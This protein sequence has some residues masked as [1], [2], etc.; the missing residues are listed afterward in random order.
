MKLF[1]SSVFLQHFAYGLIIPTLLLWQNQ[2]GLSFAEIG[3]I[4]T[5][6]VVTILLSEVPSSYMADKVGKKFTICLAFILSIVSFGVLY[7]ADSFWLFAISQFLFNLGLAFFSGTQESF[8]HDLVGEE[9]NMTK[10]LGRLSIVDESSTIIGMLTVSGVLMISDLKFGF[11]IGLISLVLGLIAMLLV[12]NVEEEDDELEVEHSKVD[13]KKYAYSMIPIVLF[14]SFMSYRGELIFQSALSFSGISLAIISI[15][16]ACAKVFS[17]IGSFY[18]HKI[19]EG[20]GIK[21]SMILTLLLQ[22]ISCGLLLV[23]EPILCVLALMIFS[24]SEN[25]YRNIRDA[26]ILKTSP[27]KLRTT[28]ISS[29]SF[30]AALFGLFINPLVGVSLDVGI[31][32]GVLVLV[33]MKVM[34]GGLILWRG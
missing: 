13:I 27:K 3:L 34:A 30:S 21:K 8:L 26:W 17:I 14:F 6:G 19:E 16:Y 28:V 7:F 32:Y 24:F 23:L 4:Q 25:V 12:G 2:V 33:A 18:A 15:V 31:V 9:G 1:Y 5:I 29:V 20:L 10:S 22:V 11:L